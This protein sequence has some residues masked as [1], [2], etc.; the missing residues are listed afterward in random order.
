[1]IDPWTW[2]WEWLRALTLGANH[3][4]PA[5]WPVLLFVA[6]GLFSVVVLAIVGLP[7][8]VGWVRRIRRRRRSV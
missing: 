5:S 8:V 1:M 2:A 3:F 7:I 6:W 4:G